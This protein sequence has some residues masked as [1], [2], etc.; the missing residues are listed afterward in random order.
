[1]SHSDAP[2]IV[3]AS[4]NPGKLAEVRDALASVGGTIRGLAEL[5]LEGEV[6]ETGDSY[7]DNARL[8]AVHWSLQ[9][10]LPALA[11]DSGLEVD[12]LAGA[13]GVRSARF[14][15]EGLDDRQRNL[16]LLESLRE[17]PPG[18]RGA[19]FRCVLVVATAGQ[20]VLQAEGSRRGRILEQLRGTAG[21]GYDPLFFVDELSGA[22]AELSAA[23]KR[24]ESHRAR[25]LRALEQALLLRGGWPGGL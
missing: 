6:A 5:D 16:L 15:G 13:P 3:F 19:C 17:V 20:V 1:M 11:D 25:A 18:E 12:A 2:L 14:G 9:S 8:K 23:V 10:G 7:A 24:S 21:F 22:F 4:G